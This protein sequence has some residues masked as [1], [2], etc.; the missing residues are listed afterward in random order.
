M[1]RLA[2]LAVLVLALGTRASAADKPAAA[3]DP[4]VKMEDCGAYMQTLI[5]LPTKF[6]ELMS[7]VADGMDAH[8]A[9]VSASKDKSAKAEAGLMK[10]LAKDHRDLASGAKKVITR[11]EEGKKLGP[12]PHDMTKMD[13]KMGELAMKQASFERELAALLIKHADETE[14]M[15][16][17]MAA[18]HAGHAPPPVA[19]AAPAKSVPP[20]K[21]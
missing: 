4:N 14:K 10:K 6:A 18:G 3:A 11:L 2:L 1:N 5:P 17:A 19:P 7:A 9:W 13:P 21:K 8:V 15:M 12:A 16:K 20:G